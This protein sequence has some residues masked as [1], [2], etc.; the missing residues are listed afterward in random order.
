MW[1]IRRRHS[2]QSAW[3]YY[4]A[5]IDADGNAL[6]QKRRIDGAGWGDFDEWTRL[7][8]DTV[9]W[10]YIADPELSSWDAA[11]PCGGDA[12]HAVFLYESPL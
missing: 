6:T 12:N 11:P 9:G 1:L 8:D 5:E 2:F 7:G 3:A 4:V 10:S